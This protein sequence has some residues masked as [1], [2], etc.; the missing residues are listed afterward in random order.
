MEVTCINME[1]QERLECAKDTLEK[2]EYVVIGGGAGLSDAAGLRFIGERFDNNFKPFIEKYDFTD[3]Y[4]SSFYAFKTIEE[5]WAYWAKH[6]SLN[7]YETP[8]TKLYLDLLELV[9]RKNYFVITTNVDHQF[10]KAGFPVDKVFAV[11]GDYGFFQC[12]RACHNQLYYNE[13]VVQA[14][15]S[16]TKD[17]KVPSALVPYCPVCGGPMDVNLRKDANF[18]QDAA[19]YV[20]SENYTSFLAKISESNVV[21]LELG[22]GFNTPG[23]IRFP[24]EQ[25]THQNPKATLIRINLQYAQGAEENKNRTIAFNESMIMVLGALC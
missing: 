1:Y 7:R 2:A 15:L 23:I 19:W 9:Q 18:V 8:A 10:F 20:A 11:Q 5:R 12:G 22:V 3:M 21:F 24:F 14:M 6:I 16:Q 4:T 13:S 17:C 25:M